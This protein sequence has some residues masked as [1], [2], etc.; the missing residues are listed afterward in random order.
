MKTTKQRFFTKGG[1]KMKVKKIV[2]EAEDEVKKADD[3]EAIA[4]ETKT[5]EAT[6]E[7]VEET[8]EEAKAEE[9][10]TDAA[11]EKS[12]EKA[13]ETTEETTEAPAEEAKAED[14]GE[15]KSEEAEAE[16]TEEEVKEVADK[17]E[18]QKADDKEIVVKLDFSD[19]KEQFEKMV[20]PLIEKIDA[21]NT[22]VDGI[23]KAAPAEGAAD[24]EETHTENAEKSEKTEDASKEEVKKSDTSSE[25]AETGN[26][27]LVEMIKSIKDSLEARLTKIESQPAPSKVVVVTKADNAEEPTELQK[28]SDRLTEIEKM[29]DEDPASYMRNTALVDEALTLVE[30]KRKLMGG[31]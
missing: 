18:M 11:E 6:A 16:K 24:A 9:A 21:V 13:E 2:I 4:E 29:R 8:K 3:A 10:A 22:K 26:E 25:G 5:E 7:T 28:V 20:S 17:A 12:E 1:E 14:A 27:K 23:G 19:F 15:A 30:K 31:K